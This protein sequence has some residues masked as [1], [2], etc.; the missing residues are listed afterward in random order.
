MSCR[1]STQ[2]ENTGRPKLFKG[3]PSH[4]QWAGHSLKMTA[5]WGARTPPWGHPMTRVGARLTP[6]LLIENDRFT[7]WKWSL[8][9]GKKN[10]A[11]VLFK[12][13]ASFYK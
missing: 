3:H 9:W 6:G 11:R 5:P 13:N 1:T 4:F 12:E 10:R 7:H 8:P 2:A